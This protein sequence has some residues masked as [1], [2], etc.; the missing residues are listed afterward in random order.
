[1]QRKA[2][3]PAEESSDIVSTRMSQAPF[4]RAVLLAS[5]TAAC[6]TDDSGPTSTPSVT[7]P[8]TDA[9][10][11]Y[12]LVQALSEHGFTGRMGTMLPLR[13]GRPLD[14]RL[15]DIGRLLFF[16]PLLG[17]NNDNS[18]AGC[19]APQHG[20][21]DTQSIAIG[22]ENNGIVGPDRAGPRNQRRTPQ[23]L[24]AAYF[25]RLMWNSR[26]ASRLGDPFDRR[27]GYLFPDPEGTS[28]SYMP[29]L[30]SAQA[31]VP[32]TERVEMAGLEFPGN[33]NDIRAEVV[34]RVNA[35]ADYKA[36]FAKVYPEVSKSAITYDHLGNAIG[37]FTFSLNFANAPIDQ[38]A[39]GDTK[40]M[41]MSQKRGALL[42]FGK[43]G[44]VGCHAVSGQSNEM[45][46]DFREHVIGVPQIV[47]AVTNVTYDGSAENEDFGKGQFTGNID[48]RYAFRTSPI[49]NVALQ[50][51]FMHNGVY[52]RLEDAINHHLDVVY[53][54]TN[55]SPA[56][57]GVAADLRGPMGPLGPIL[58]RLDSRLRTPIELTSAE[59]DQLLEFV[60]VGLMDPAASSSKLRALIP[61]NLP[62]RKQLHT[63]R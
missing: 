25:P 8:L 61:A 24:N 34:R 45:F 9:Q 63:F 3:S 49:R 7:D 51:T 20:F 54:A 27:A 58:E 14:I 44:C 16:D 4:F 17:L 29:H 19:H 52:T 28:L 12:A 35:V 62:S 38:Y 47:P 60:K 22:I 18:C 6:S 41:T 26:F 55:Y 5:V 33:N 48:D 32:P 36:L 40:A 42:F 39:R 50:T 31:F 11:D 23:L 59:F 56:A 57:A 30:L 37:E 13:L 43:A 53:W 10:V 21:G 1:M 46:S 15:A 2:I